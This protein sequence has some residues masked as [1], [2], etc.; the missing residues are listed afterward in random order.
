MKEFKNVARASS[1]EE[2]QIPTQAAEVLG[3]LCLQ[4][5]GRVTGLVTRPSHRH[6]GTQMSNP[7]PRT[8]HM[9]CRDYRACARMRACKTRCLKRKEMAPMRESRKKLAFLHALGYGG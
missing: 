6:T 4:E 2:G 3:V 1:K 5:L 7:F 8:D 9:T